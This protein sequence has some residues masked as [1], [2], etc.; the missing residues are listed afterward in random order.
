VSVE[1]GVVIRCVGVKSRPFKGYFWSL[2]RGQHDSTVGP[3]GRYGEQRLEIRSLKLSSLL[4]VFDHQLPPLSYYFV[5]KSVLD[6][7]NVY[8]ILVAARL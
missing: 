2:D 5:P 6:C 4:L 1:F 8:E 7:I 3:C